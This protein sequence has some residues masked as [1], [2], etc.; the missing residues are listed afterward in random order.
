MDIF[1]CDINGYDLC[2]MI[3]SDPKLNSVTI[4]LLTTLT[5]KE[6]ENYNGESQADGYI[7]KPFDF[8]DFD[9]I[10]NLLQNHHRD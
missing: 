6:I 3:K 9:K 10:L 1:L 4:Y 5:K 2:R 8:E 7:L